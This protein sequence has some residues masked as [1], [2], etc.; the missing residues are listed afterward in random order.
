[1]T[2][3]HTCLGRALSDSNSSINYFELSVFSALWGICFSLKATPDK[4][5]RLDSGTL[6]GQGRAC[7]TLLFIKA[8]SWC[9][10]DNNHVCSG[11]ASRKP[12]R[13][14][15]LAVPSLARS[16]M[17]RQPFGLSAKRE[18]MAICRVNTTPQLT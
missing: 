1:M 10:R 17:L 7:A 9:N 13:C 6:L 15:R 18:Y 4:M 14:F 11:G 16:R 5:K 2:Y 3:E 8:V 12:T